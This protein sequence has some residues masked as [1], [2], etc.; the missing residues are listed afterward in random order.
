MKTVD[1][2]IE[3]E[4]VGTPFSVEGSSAPTALALAE[5]TEISADEMAKIG[6]IVPAVD[7]AKIRAA[8]KLKQQL[9][10]AILDPQ[11]DFLYTIS[12][13]EANGQQRE[14]RT[15]SYADIKKFSDTYKVPYKANPKKS[16]ITKL[17]AALQIEAKRIKVVGLPDDPKA[18]F[19]HVEYEA[20]H[21]PSGR[22]AIGIGWCDEDEKGGHKNSDRKVPRHHVIATADTR[23]FNRAVLR[24]AGFGDVSAE[25]IAAISDGEDG[26]PV[27]VDHGSM[28]AAPPQAKPARERPPL[29]DDRV[30]AA[31]RAWAE[32]IAGRRE[33]DRFAALPTQEKNAGWQEMRARARRG[34]VDA[35]ARLGKLGIYWHGLARDGSGYEAWD[36]EQPPVTPEDILNARASQPAATQ[37]TPAA[38]AQPAAAQPA[39]QST[40]AAATEAPKTEAAAPSATTTPSTESAPAENA[41]P[42]VPSALGQLDVITGAQAEKLSKALV[43]KFQGNRDEARAWL[44]K[45]AGVERTT[46]VRSDQFERLMSMLTEEGA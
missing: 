5:R 43:A 14:Y 9:Y 4:L 36:V 2:A 8:F 44:R 3:G 25:E 10:T 41:P 29:D 34:D 37:S 15:T 13:K 42:T 30:L 39:T 1:E 23:G 35:A 38:A 18:T 6:L 40:P 19:S 11:T 31:C 12:F 26:E 24:L 7:P 45:T 32:Q 16:G 27:I 20:I 22:T 28:P 46:M 33:G 17:A 21:M